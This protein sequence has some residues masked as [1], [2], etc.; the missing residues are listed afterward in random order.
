MKI[1]SSNKLSA[2]KYEQIIHEYQS[3]ISSILKI[4]ND[5]RN[6]ASDIINSI[7]LN[8]DIISEYLKDFPEFKPLE[9]NLFNSIENYL[10]KIEEKKKLEIQ[11][12]KLD[13]FQQSLPEEVELLQLNNELMKKDLIKIIKKI[14]KLQ[15]E[16]DK[17]KT[18]SVYKIP[19]EEVFIISPTKKNIE[20]NDLIYRLS[21]EQK[22]NYN[23]EIDKRDL[24]ILDAKIKI[25][26][27]QVDKLNQNINNNKITGDTN[28][29][30][31]NEDEEIEEAD[32]E[33]KIEEDDFDEDFNIGELTKKKIESEKKNEENENLELIEQINYFK[34]QVEKLEKENN[35]TKNKIQIYDEEYKNLCIELQKLEDINA[36][37]NNNNDNNTNTNKDNNTNN[38]KINNDNFLKKV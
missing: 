33:D 25:I 30:E 6:E 32:G 24:K 7:Y 5:L 1:N 15:K 14:Y 3:K 12:N 13:H 34:T 19:R 8:R 11:L 9:K 28:N 35:D 23:Q 27:E 2:Q 38:N 10:E 17:R 29:D 16:I 36:K 20:L 4:N 18:N 22:N 37:K 31:D 21:K 26:E